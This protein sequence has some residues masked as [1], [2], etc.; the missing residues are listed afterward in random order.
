SEQRCA[1]GTGLTPQ[2][3]RMV[4]LAYLGPL[5]TVK[6]GNL[7]APQPTVRGPTDGSVGVQR[8]APISP[9]ACTTIGS[10]SAPSWQRERSTEL[11]GY[12]RRRIRSARS[13]SYFGDSRLVRP[14]PTV[15]V[16]S[17]TTVPLD[18]STHSAR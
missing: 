4:G 18:G 15:Q 14:L 6:H 8:L 9:S 3:Q 17:P 1:A 12:W 16:L 2:F 11:K 13:T 7:G 10:A 5:N